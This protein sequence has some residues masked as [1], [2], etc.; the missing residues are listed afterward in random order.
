MSHI[1]LSDVQYINLNVLT[2]IKLGIQQ[3]KVATCCRFSLDAALA[4]L[5]GS[6]SPEQIWAIVANVGHASL[7]PPRHDL[8]NLLQTPLPLVG[9]LVA[10]RLPRHNIQPHGSR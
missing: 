4:E 3:D 9:P 2:A 5:I 7:F 6:L 1:H 8:I 10:V